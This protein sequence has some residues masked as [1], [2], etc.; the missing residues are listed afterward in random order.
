MYL[1]LTNAMMKN[2]AG[3]EKVGWERVLVRV[4]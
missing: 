4:R 2:G 1:M 3:K